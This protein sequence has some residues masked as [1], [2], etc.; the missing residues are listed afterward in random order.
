MEAIEIK[1]NGFVWWFKDNH[2][3]EF[4]TSTVGIYIY[5]KFITKSERSQILNQISHGK[6]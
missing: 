3:L 5:S 1:V 2:L 4:K 6:N